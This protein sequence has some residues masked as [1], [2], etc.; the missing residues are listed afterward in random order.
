MGWFKRA[1]EGIHTPTQEK[2]ETPEGLWHKCS[3][4]DDVI[5]SEDH[6]KFLWVC[7]KCDHHGRIGSNNVYLNN[8]K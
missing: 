8:I 2:K 3:S 1:K 4:C 5:T 7:D 6:A